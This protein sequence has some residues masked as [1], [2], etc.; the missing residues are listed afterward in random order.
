MKRSNYLWIFFAVAAC[1]ASSDTPEETI[2]FN[3]AESRGEIENPLISEAS[4]L[5]AAINNP[6]MLWT[7]ND[8]GNDPH[9]FLLD[10]NGKDK[11]TFEL[12]G[13]NNRDWEDISSGPG[14][15]A[16]KNYLYIAEMGDNN[17]VH[18][19]KYIYRFEEPQA[20]GPKTIEHVETITFQYPDGKRDAECLMIDPLTKDLY[21]ISKRE[22]N[23]GVYRATYPQSTEEVITLEKLGSIPFK[24]IVAG[25]ISTDGTEILLKT[26]DKILYWKRSGN[27]ELIKVLEEEPIEIFYIPEPQGEAIAWRKNRDGFFTLSE[28]RG[29]IEAVLFFYQKR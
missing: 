24:N 4:G 2:A 21:I 18:E 6:D 25:D 23:V 11:G 13:F 14:P 27:Q 28:E 8:S 15:D 17:A 29:G 5:A 9:I 20:D 22:E 12:K 16:N 7:H 1:S 19:L 10:E 3:V 26:Y